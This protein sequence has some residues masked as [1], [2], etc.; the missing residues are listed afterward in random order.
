MGKTVPVLSDST[1]AKTVR[2]TLSGQE[3]AVPAVTCGSLKAKVGATQDCDVTI[4]DDTT[5]LH[6]TVD[7]VKGSDVHWKQE[8]FLH[9]SAVQSTVAKA[10]G[11]SPSDLTCP[12]LPGTMG[13]SVSCQVLKGSAASVDV[14]VT[15]VD[16][17]R[18]GV[19]YKAR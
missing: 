10:T 17:L 6:L 14:T 8:P 1:V 11:A 19:S 12:D 4:N 18:I 2:G 5:G 13:A 3:T 16:G 7:S 15:S 9:G